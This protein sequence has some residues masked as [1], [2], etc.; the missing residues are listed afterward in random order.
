MYLLPLLLLLFLLPLL[1]L[2][3][4]LRPL[5]LL[6]LL[7]LLLLLLLLFPLLLLLLLLRPLLLLLLLLFLFLLPLLPLL[8]LPPP[9]PSPSSSSSLM[10]CCYQRAGSTWSLWYS[11]CV[12]L[13]THSPTIMLCYCSPL[14]PLCSQYVEHTS[15]GVC[16]GH[17]V[18][19]LLPYPPFLHILSSLWLSVSFPP[20]FSVPSS[21]SSPLS[22]SLCLCLLIPL[23]SCAA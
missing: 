21:M 19:P 14:L 3:L 8:L 22:L 7:P 6:L 23:G 1:L 12:S 4:L 2:L 9:P 13:P 15:P 16:E 5:L 17:L 11:V 20:L 18:P 10:Q